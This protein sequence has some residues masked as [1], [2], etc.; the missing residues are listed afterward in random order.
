M[1]AIARFVLL[2]KGAQESG[3]STILKQ[4]RMIY[5][6][7]YSTTQLCDFTPIALSNIISSLSGL[8]E[9]AT[10]HG[11]PIETKQD[12]AIQ[13]QKLCSADTTECDQVISQLLALDLKRIW[14]DKGIQEIFQSSTKSY[15]RRWTFGIQQY[16][17][18]KCQCQFTNCSLME[19]HDQIMAPHYVPSLEDILNIRERTRGL[20]ELRLPYGG[21][22]LNVG[23]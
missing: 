9:T 4:L 10:E 5:T 2:P 6:P 11:V 8:I 1:D 19:R 18:I 15:Q 17:K 23:R 13:L 3:K 21:Q 20:V 22:S 14:N 16:A 12:V 7:G